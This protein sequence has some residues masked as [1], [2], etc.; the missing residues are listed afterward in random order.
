MGAKGRFI[1]TT[2]KDTMDSIISIHE[3]LIKNPFYLYNDKKGVKVKYYNQNTEKSTLDKGSGLTHSNIGD[4]SSIRFNVIDN[5]FIYQF[6]KAELNFE[7]GEFGL[8]SEEISGES[9]ILPNTIIPYDGDYFEVPYIK[10]SSWLFRVISSQKDTLENGSNVYRIN[11]TLDRTTNK[12]ILTNV[13]EYYEYINVREGTNIKS[14]V[15]KSNYD[16]ALRLEDL[17]SSLKEYFIDLFYS[18]TIQTFMFEYH[19]KAVMY[20]PFLIE[21]IIRNNL[22]E[23]DNS[24]YIYIDHKINPGVTFN[25]DYKKSLYYAF[26]KRDIK[27]FANSIYQSQADMISNSG[28]IFNIWNDNIYYKMNYRM[29]NTNNPYQYIIP[30]MDEELRDNI[31][32]N[33]RYE[34]DEELY[35]NIF[36]KYFNNEDIYEEDFACID[37]IDYGTNRE[38]F[39]N[40]ILLIFCIDYYI[41]YILTV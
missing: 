11:W 38:I 20:D 39:Y 29:A 41:K 33:N 1:N 4:N 28:S 31:L 35:K 30:I 7:N 37:Y 19:A 14:V 12:D 15:K 3:D 18:N 10:D 32:N 17:S 5:L 9:Y 36:I 6:P 2:Y 34:D 8:E 40:I 26:E 25:I 27:R 13:V 24:D 23:R 22:L 16:K 21:F